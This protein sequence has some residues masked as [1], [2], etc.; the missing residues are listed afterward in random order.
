MKKVLSV[1]FGDPHSINGS[2]IPNWNE[3]FLPLYK[4]V[5][6]LIDVSVQQ[7]PHI[8]FDKIRVIVES[9]ISSLNNSEQEQIKR[10]VATQNEWSLEK[11]RRCLLFLC[12]K[13][14]ELSLIFQNV[15]MLADIAIEGVSKIIGRIDSSNFINAKMILGQLNKQQWTRDKT[16]SERQGSTSILG[17]ISESLLKY[18]TEHFID[19]ENFFKTNSRD[20]QSYGDFVLM[21]L[22]NNLWISVKSQ[23][24]RE[25][26]LASGYTTDIVG[27]GF[28]SDYTEFT[29]KTKIRNFQRVGFLAMYIPDVAVTE[30]QE[31][32]NISTY[33]E[34][35]DY[36]KQEGIKLPI[37]ING[38]NFLRP[39]SSIGND[40]SSLLAKNLKS[41]TT[42]NF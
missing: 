16:L 7:Y 28:F 14:P 42:V 36:Y 40:L 20:I 17:S 26:L 15:N 38:T 25:R 10:V 24:A 21:C 11:E 5:Y 39:L 35:I 12:Q 37:N 22:P 29:S 32:K 4:E 9:L 30:E 1:N 6:K 34:T 8:N 19:D 27:V 13:L 33:Q 41:R 3:F 2:D 18:A 23:F 31:D